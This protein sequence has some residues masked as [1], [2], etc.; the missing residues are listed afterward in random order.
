M[1]IFSL[2]RRPHRVFYWPGAQGMVLGYRVILFSFFLNRS[3]TLILILD[4]KAHK[5]LRQLPFTGK[6]LKP[7]KFR[8][9]YWR[10]L[11]M[12]QI[13]EGC[14]VVGRSV[15][16]LLM[17]CKKLHELYWEDS[18][19]YNKEGKPLNRHERG[20]KIN[21]Q[22]I[23]TIADM[24][25]ILGGQGKGNKIWQ[26]VTED[27]KELA[28]LDV[29]EDTIVRD[30]DGVVKAR[31]KAEVWWTDIQNHKHARSWTS[32]VT[33]YRFEDAALEKLLD[34]GTEEENEKG[35]EEEDRE[36]DQES[37]P[38]KSDPKQAEPKEQPQ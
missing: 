18:L 38:E 36:E 35:D 8:R 15:Y 5:A 11:A 26:K 7:S 10:P 37:A 27:P 16:N 32:N 34:E 14:G 13:P 24:A 20:R 30:E 17:E 31:V 6:K 1:G 33:H 28:I 29:G 4:L 2:P 19:L 3:K 23:N 12:I 25:A 21:D 22:R 9:D